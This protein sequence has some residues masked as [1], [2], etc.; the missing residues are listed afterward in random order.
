MVED[1]RS[2]LTINKVCLEN[3]NVKLS[4]CDRVDA[5]SNCPRMK[6]FLH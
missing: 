3:I 6:E 1:T 5:A 2:D 4:E